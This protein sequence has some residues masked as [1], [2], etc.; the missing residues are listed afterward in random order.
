ME[1]QDSVETQMP[2]PPSAAEKAVA[3]PPVLDPSRWEDFEGFRETFLLNFS[4]PESNA[5]MRSL[6]RVLYHLVLESAHVMPVLPGGWL[7]GNLLAALADLRFVEG[8]LAFVGEERGS[9]GLTAGEEELCRSVRRKARALRRIA[10]ALGDELG[11]CAPSE[12]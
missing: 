11:V 12:P 9:E 5:A 10:D 6:G 7:R 1:P 4:D 3:F 8:F 2:T